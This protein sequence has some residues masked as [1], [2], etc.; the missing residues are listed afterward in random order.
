V[1]HVGDDWVE[2]FY[3]ALKPWVHYIPVA[4]DLGDIEELLEFVKSHDQLAQDIA[5][6]GYELVWN[7]VTLQTVECYWLELLTEYAS[8]LQWTVRR[9]ISLVAL[10][11]S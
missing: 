2:F 7:H 8:L 5:Q 4:E 1:F 6:R 9:D 11:M 10:T 3:P